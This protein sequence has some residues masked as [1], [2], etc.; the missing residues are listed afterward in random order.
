MLR[1]PVID[2]ATRLAVLLPKGL[3][4]AMFLSTGA[5]SYEAAVKMAKV[6]TAKFELI[7]LGGSWHGVTGGAQA[8]SYRTGRKGYGPLVSE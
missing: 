8:T 2:L 5:E 1:T 6:Y 3:D 7:G 4:R